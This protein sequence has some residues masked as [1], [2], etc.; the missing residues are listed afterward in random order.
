LPGLHTEASI[1]A[2]AVGTFWDTA[3]VLATTVHTPHVVLFD[4]TKAATATP[5]SLTLLTKLRLTALTGRATIQPINLSAKALFTALS[6]TIAPWES[7][8]LL[9]DLFRQTT[10]LLTA[11]EIRAESCSRTTVATV[12]PHLLAE[13][14]RGGLT[15]LLLDT[16]PTTLSGQSK[17]SLWTIW[18]HCVA[19]DL[20]FAGAMMRLATGDAVSAHW[21]GAAATVLTKLGGRTVAVTAAIGLP[22]RAA[23]VWV[24]AAVTVSL[25]S[26]QLP[27][28]T[29]GRL[30]LTA[31][32]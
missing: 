12:A 17:L 29:Q 2:A 21:A 4:T 19:E 11:Q 25:P 22:P 10:A 23:G 6:A 27:I 24:D 26:Q 3:V 20:W 31:G 30:H 13:A 5:L 8:T 16:E 18:A 7:A 14:Q 15:A 28:L 32:L 9:P 1:G